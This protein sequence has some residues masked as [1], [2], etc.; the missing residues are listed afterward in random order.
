MFEE[1]EEDIK[2]ILENGKNNNKYQKNDNAEY[3]KI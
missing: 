1:L 2:Q 3:F